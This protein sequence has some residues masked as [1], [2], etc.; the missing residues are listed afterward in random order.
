MSKPRTILITAGP[1][2]EDIDPVRFISNRASGRLGVEI[3]R[4]ALRRKHKVILVHGPVPV[5]VLRIVGDAR[6]GTFERKSVRSA[7]EMR[8]AVRTALPG[9]DA[10]VMN[11]AVADYTPSKVSKAKLKKDRAGLLL[12]L[13][14]TAD[15]LA[16]LGRIKRTRKRRLTLVGFALETGRGRTEAARARARLREARRKLSEKNLDAIVLDTPA[17]IGVG[18]GVFEVLVGDAQP[19]VFRGSK[20]AF[21]ARLIDLLET[22][23]K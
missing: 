22:L 14:P 11:A 2:V 15:I 21:G 19:M 7:A 8:R 5:E 12:R 13:K 9:L 17:E 23:L 4:A 3:A 1:T 18:S 10:V 16:E 6:R 20:R